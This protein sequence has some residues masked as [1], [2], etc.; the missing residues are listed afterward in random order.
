MNLW[1]SLWFG[2]VLAYFGSMLFTYGVTGQLRF[3]REPYFVVNA[4][5][6]VCGWPVTLPG[7]GLLH[8]LQVRRVRREVAQLKQQ[9]LDSFEQAE[10]P[11]SVGVEAE[12]GGGEP[13]R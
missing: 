9:L 7:M 8:A 2:G 4:L 5:I 10:M 6:M 3:F 13:M 12:V 11:S 1:L